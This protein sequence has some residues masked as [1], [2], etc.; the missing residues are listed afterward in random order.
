LW[1]HANYR[2]VFHAN[3]ATKLSLWDYLFGTVYFPRDKKPGN[4]PENWG[5]YYDY[6]RDYFLQH[7]FSV[8]RFDEKTLLKYKWFR[9]Y[10]NLRPS[11]LKRLFP[12]GKNKVTAAN[13]EKATGKDASLVPL[14][15]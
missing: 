8:K 5:L 13:I 4:M 10:Y 6:P 3:F 9:K 11:L 14:N 12:S 15:K 1:H 2:E 7:A